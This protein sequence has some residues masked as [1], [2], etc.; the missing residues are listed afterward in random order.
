MIDAKGIIVKYIFIR[1]CRV[2]N[3]NYALKYKKDI[4]SGGFEKN[5]VNYR[6]RQ[7]I[8]IFTKFGSKNIVEVGCG[9][10]PIFCWFTNFKKITII[11]R[12]REF[13][14]IAN[15]FLDDQKNA[16]SESVS[17]INK[18]LEDCKDLGAE[19][20]FIVL[21]SI[22]H[23]VDNPK[24]FMNHLKSMLKGEEYIYIN[25]PNANS[26]HR[27]IA[28]EA[29][30]IK[31]QSEVSSRGSSFNTMRVFT[32]DDLKNL[33]VSSGF[34]VEDYGTIGL[35]PFTHVQMDKI[36]DN[37]NSASKVLTKALFNSDNIV[38]G[39]G[40]EIWMLLRVSKK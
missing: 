9:T 22:L 17:I 29:G 26:L 2:N 12:S 31:N 4:D 14:D 38:K 5:L 35:K 34:F 20:D 24:S 25:V 11:E 39:I 28:L 7:L 37:K 6:R 30:I 19:S 1:I 15:A 16:N 27:L 32:I 23:E 33:A 21:S 8:E 18:S 13:C 10:D 3:L 36:I 40:S